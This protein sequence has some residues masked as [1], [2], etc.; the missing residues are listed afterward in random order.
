MSQ[1]ALRTLALNFVA[2]TGNLTK[3]FSRVT[4]Q[5]SAFVG[6][7]TRIAG[8]VSAIAGLL[9]ASIS[10]AGT[11]AAI[12]SQ[13]SL[14]DALAKTSDKL[15]ISTEDLAAFQHQADLA[16]VSSKA[17]ETSIQKMVRSIDDAARGSK[18]AADTFK[19]LGLDPKALQA[20]QTVEAYRDI[21][22]A[23][24]AVDSDQKQLSTTLRI[25]GRSGGDMIHMLRG[26]SDAFKDAKSDAEAFGLAVSRIDAGTVELA[27]DEVTRMKAALSGIVRIAAVQIAP[28]IARIAHDFVEWAKSGD[29]AARFVADAFGQVV[30]ILG[31]IGNMV[32]EFRQNWI[33]LQ[34][35]ILQAQKAW[36]ENL[37]ASPESLKRAQL[38]GD[39][40]SSLQKTLSEL[41]IDLAVPFDKRIQQYI[42]EARRWAREVASLS[43]PERRAFLEPAMPAFGGAGGVSSGPR[44]VLRGSAEAAATEARFFNRAVSNPMLRE[45]EEANDHLKRIRQDIGAIRR[46]QESGTVG[47][48]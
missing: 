11:I 34:I 10:V 17:F 15:S 47:I 22:E 24:A 33:A 27:N 35:V 29:N 48:D 16:G 39:E 19:E 28:V 3:A 23:I 42:I 18:E 45:Q 1:G 12:K 25:F 2:N 44:G 20:K 7:I 9:G 8:R 41:S 43:G 46:N 38:I 37:F 14:V 32:D 21:A 6:G 36:N 26:G 30:A 13:M 31:T 4:K 5:V 40:I